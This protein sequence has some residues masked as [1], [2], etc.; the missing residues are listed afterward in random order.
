MTVIDVAEPEAPRAPDR[1]RR[2]ALMMPHRQRLVRLATAQL[3]NAHDAEDCVHEAMLR[4][5]LFEALDEDR[6][7][8]FLTTVVVRLCVD[9][10]RAAARARTALP[11]LWEGGRQESPEDEVCDQLSGAWLLRALGDLPARERSVMRAR[12]D[13]LSTTEAAQRLGI[14]Q[15]AAESAF[16]RA[17]AKIHHV[18][19]SQP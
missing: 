6:I 7:S 18:S 17:R 9:R 12:A 10:H 11:R 16:T 4:T 14:T 5:V 13:G 3:G 19:R 1:C 2:W 15:K 8:A